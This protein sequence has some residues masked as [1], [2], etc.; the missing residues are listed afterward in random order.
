MNRYLL[1]AV[2]AGL[3]LVAGAAPTASAKVT[4]EN[5]D[6][7]PPGCDSIQGETQITVHAGREQ[8]S[9]FN[10]AVFTFDNRSW[11]VDPCTKVTVTFVNE[12]EIRHQFMVHGTYPRDPGFFQIEVTGPGEDT[13][14]S[15]PGP[16]RRACSCTAASAS[17]SR[18]A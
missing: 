17:T 3:V 2:L 1:L 14:P 9:E 10:G 12:D 11:E 16:T 6:D 7:P 18:R 5:T 13:G 15:S 4:N 8:A